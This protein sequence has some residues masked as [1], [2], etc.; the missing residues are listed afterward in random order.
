V[1]RLTEKNRLENEILKLLTKDSRQSYR[2]LAKQLNT[3]HVSVSNK[4]KALEE[5]GVISGY[6]TVIDP[7][8]MGY[9]PICLRISASQGGNLMEIG[10]K[11]SDFPEINIVV[12]VSG[13]CEI[14]ALAMCESRESALKLLNQI[15]KING[16]TKAESHIVLEA[17][18]LGGFKLKS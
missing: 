10:D 9:Y 17:L 7:Y 3:S 2:E 15:N 13:E 4:I 5:K 1:I 14:L 18:K 12:R 11:I 6:T 16:I 8:K